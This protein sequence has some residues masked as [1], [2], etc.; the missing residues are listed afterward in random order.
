MLSLRQYAADALDNA[1]AGLFI[2]EIQSILE[3]CVNEK[4]FK[5]K[6][7]QAA[8]TFLYV[9]RFRIKDESFLPK[10]SREFE[11]ILKSLRS[12][13]IYL[14]RMGQSSRNARVAEL[15]LGIEKYMNYEG[16]ANIV[17]LIDE[18]FGDDGKESDDVD[19]E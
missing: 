9:L 12:A 4:N 1:Q 17:A 3:E 8:R 16:S 14:K 13:Q 19:D 15:I 2:Q 5:M 11:N 18:L 7:L 6:F 10:G